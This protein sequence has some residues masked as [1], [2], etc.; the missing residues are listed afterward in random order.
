MQ[1][2][3]ILL[4]G[5]F[6]LLLSLYIYSSSHAQEQ[7]IQIGSNLSHVNTDSEAWFN[8]SGLKI[9]YGYSLG[10]FSNLNISFSH[11]SFF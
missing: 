6:F 8:A 7:Q 9:G 3:K 1:Y 2:L 5:K 11:I 4:R 10:E